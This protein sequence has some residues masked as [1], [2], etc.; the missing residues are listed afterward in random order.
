MPKTTPIPV[1]LDEATL[2]EVRNIAKQHQMPVSTV[3]SAL[4]THSVNL[5]LDHNAKPQELQR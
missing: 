1:R 3:I 2:M 5:I 4:T